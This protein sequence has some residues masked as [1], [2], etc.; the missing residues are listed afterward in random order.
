MFWSESSIER[1]AMKIWHVVKW[2]TLVVVIVSAVLGISYIFLRKA[3]IPIES[4]LCDTPTYIA[5]DLLEDS[6]TTCTTTSDRLTINVSFPVYVVAIISF[7]GWIFFILFAGVGFATYPIDCFCEFRHRPKKMSQAELY[8]KKHKLLEHVKSL[9]AE[10]KSL[11]LRQEQEK[12]KKLNF[13]QKWIVNT[14]TKLSRDTARFEARCLIAEREFLIVDQ[15]EHWSK[16]RNCLKWVKLFAGIFLILWNIVWVFHI[17]LYQLV[18]PFGRPATPF[19]NN[20]LDWLISKQV[21]FVAAIIFILLTFY[22]LICAFKGNAKLGLRCFCMSLY[23]LNV[24]ETYM[25]AFCFNAMLCNIW[26][27]SM[28]QFMCDTF[29]QYVRGSDAHLIF[30]VFLKYMYFYEYF[31]RYN[32]FLIALLVWIL[33]CT[34]Y[35]IIRP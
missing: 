12:N 8:S 18:K 27:M 33:I 26:G 32:I 31:Y 21:E 30:N 13:R 19:L 1:I 34:V 29:E 2:E 23:P 24:N 28:L 35:F 17:L 22:M 3:R 10:S 5:S 16:I 15:S 20:V 9:L 4:M 11:S 6:Y 14:N 25:N 7:V